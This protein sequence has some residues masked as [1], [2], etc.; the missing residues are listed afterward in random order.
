MNWSQRIKGQAPAPP[1]AS[2]FG[3]AGG[4]RKD[5][6]TTYVAY[7]PSE[8]GMTLSPPP[9]TLRHPGRPGLEDPMFEQSSTIE[10]VFIKWYLPFGPDQSCQIYLY[11]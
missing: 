10:V 9:L 11:M 5:L 4:Y 3:M 8:D 7:Q 2:I 6:Y 1:N